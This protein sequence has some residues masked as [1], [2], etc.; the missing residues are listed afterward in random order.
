M[1][2]ED[3]AH[4]APQRRLVRKVVGYVVRNG[5]L[6][7][8]THDDVPIEVAGVQVPAGTVEPG[9]ERHYF[10]LDVVEEEAPERWAAGE[11]VPSDGGAPQRWTC[12][13]TPLEHAHVLSA[14]FGAKLA[15]IAW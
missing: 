10:Q 11:A 7:V 6:L 3:R 4:M 2:M 1:T 8:F 9:H 12:W 15:Q 5:K 13:W 14:G